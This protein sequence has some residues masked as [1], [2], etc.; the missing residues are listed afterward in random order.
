MPDH[1]FR[2]PAIILFGALGLAGILVWLE[3]RIL[4]IWQDRL[5]PNRVGPFG[6]FQLG[7]DM[8]KLIMKEDW[9]AP[10][11]D[12][13]AFVMSP[14]I[15]V[16]AVMAPLA[17]VTFAPG[18]VVADLDIGLLFFLGM[19]SLAVYGAALAGWASNSKYSLL[20]GLR[21]MGQMV[22][23]EVF[24]GLSLMGVVILSGSFRLSAIVEAQKGLWYC[25]PQFPGLLL[26]LV[27]ASAEMRRTPFD[28]PEAESEL[29]AGYHSEYSGMKFALFY[30]SEY[31]GMILLSMF[32]TLL[33]FG[34]WLGPAFLPPVAWFSI[35]TAV[36]IVFF[37]LVRATLPRLRYDQLMSL[38]WKGMLP[39]SLVNLLVTGAIVLALAP[40][41]GP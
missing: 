12:R 16:A 39:L 40:G 35:K 19:S 34:G 10:F 2:L 32:I 13:I 18:L 28:L 7:A 26:F 36:L 30:F 37:I 14:S 21:A 8:I 4:A 1:A 3:R 27:A 5:G 9:V 17:V 31:V 24:M 33:F 15:M 23:Y 25:V 11:A 6:A 29:V 22:S 41:A 38:G 20:G